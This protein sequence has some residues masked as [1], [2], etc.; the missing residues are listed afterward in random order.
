MSRVDYRAQRTSLSEQVVEL[1]QRYIDDHDLEVGDPLPTEFVLA[2][3]FG[4]SRT[5]IREATKTLA[6]LG[7][8]DTQSGRRLRLR[9]PSSDVL[10]VYF[11]NVLRLD[12]SAV[13]ELLEVRE[14][15]ETYAVRAAAQNRDDD[16]VLRLEA[17]ER[18]MASHIEND[19]PTFIDEDVAFHS[20]IAKTSGN[21]VLVFLVEGLRDAMKASIAQGLHA[22]RVR[23][24]LDTITHAHRNIVEAVRR[25][26]EDAAATAMRHHFRDA[27]RTLVTQ[28]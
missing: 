21:T 19:K 15:L 8:V 22:R 16:D 3:L 12:D 10:S 2:E 5:V 13:M 17:L 24:D 7:V 1:L 25:R 20:L 9:R 6:A 4:V 18:A 27:I 23:A 11:T 28:R 14:A 26:D